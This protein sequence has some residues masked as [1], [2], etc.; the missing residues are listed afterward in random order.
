LAQLLVVAGGGALGARAIRRPT[1]G[2]DGDTRGI[3][4]VNAERERVGGFLAGMVFVVYAQSSGAAPA[5]R[6]FTAVGF[7]GALTTFSAF[8]VETLVQLDQGNWRA[9]A[10][11]VVVNLGISLSRR[12][13]AIPGARRLLG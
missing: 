8:S 13:C 7:L 12:A 11:N 9:A 1:H 10:L 2:R 3:F 5:P 6:L 4:V